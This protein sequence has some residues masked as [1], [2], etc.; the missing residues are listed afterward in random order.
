LIE[1]LD[2]HVEDCK[3]VVLDLRFLKF[4]SDDEEQSLTDTSTNVKYLFKAFDDPR[5]ADKTHALRQ[6]CKLAGV[7][8]AFFADNRPPVRESIVGNWLKSMAPEEGD[9]IL[10]LLKV[11]EGQGINVIRAILPVDYATVTNANVLRCFCS[12][13]T[14]TTV[15]LDSVV[16]TDRDEL[17]FQARIFY[18]DALEGDEY[19]A[20]VVVTT[21]DLGSSDLIIDLYLMHKESKSCMA[22][23]YGGKPFAKVSFTGVQPAEILE[24]LNSVTARLKEEAPRYLQSLKDAEGSYPSVERACVLISGK[25]GVPKK[26]KR[27]IHLEATECFEDMATLKDFIRHAGIVAKDF[28]YS[29]RLK[30]ERAVGSFG[31]LAYG[32]T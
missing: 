30:I 17:L 12:Y 9:E 21:S 32:K 18:D 31:G 11:R 2:K 20:G 15:D 19:Y 26:F 14:D 23:Q 28:G 1:S 3:D 5:D 25:K 4:S 13:P 22:A 7:P 29:D 10:T 8:Y 16:G 27:S 6:L 24:I